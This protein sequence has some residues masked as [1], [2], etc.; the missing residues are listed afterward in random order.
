[1]AKYRVARGKHVEGGVMY[2]RG[3]I[4]DSRSDLNRHNHAGAI[5]FELLPDDTPVTPKDQLFPAP[6]ASPRPD[7]PDRVEFSEPAPVQ[8]P[9]SSG[10]IGP[11][12]PTPPPS[13]PPKAD[14]FAGMNLEAKS[15]KE[16]QEIAADEE[17]DI[18]GAKSREEALALLKA[19]LTTPPAN[20]TASTMPKAQPPSSGKK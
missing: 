5:K 6:G 3:D 1:M 18:K 15:L 20:P 11:H 16:L 7:H 2:N 13:S 17:I 14:P 10:P 12:S 19:G 8:S 9:R 4:L